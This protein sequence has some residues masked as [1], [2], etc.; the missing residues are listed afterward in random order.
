LELNRKFLLSLQL[1]HLVLR[2]IR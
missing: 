1:N 2:L